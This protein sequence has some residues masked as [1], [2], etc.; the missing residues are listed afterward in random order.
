MLGKTVFLGSGVLYGK[1]ILFS[2]RIVT[3]HEIIRAP[4]PP[5]PPLLKE[6]HVLQ[7]AADQTA[8]ASFPSDKHWPNCTHPVNRGF[9]STQWSNNMSQ[10]W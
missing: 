8:G 3:G 2:C 10:V 1:S 7:I 4:E 6:Q 5:L 9:Q